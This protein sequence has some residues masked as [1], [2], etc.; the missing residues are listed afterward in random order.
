MS[1]PESDSEVVTL[2]D[3][4][5]EKMYEL[6]YNMNTTDN[7]EEKDKDQIPSSSGHT[8]V[9]LKTYSERR[10]HTVAGNTK[11]LDMEAIDN[12]PGIPE[13]KVNAE[14]K[15]WRKAGADLSDY[16]NYGFDE[17]SW[18]AYCKKQSKVRTAN[19]KLCT[20]IMVQKG[21]TRH[22]EKESCSTCHSSG[23]STILATRQSSV[24]ADVIGG[25]PGSSTRV[26]GRQCLSDEGNNT[27]VVTEMSP[28]KNRITSYHLPPPSTINSLFA[29][30]PP[31]SFLYRPGPPPVSLL[32]TFDSGHSKGS[33]DPST[34]LKPCS[35]GVS[36]LI[37]RSM[38][39]SAGVI[40][41]AKAWECYIWQEK[42]DKDRDRSRQ[43]GHDKDSQRGRDRDRKSCSSS[44][45]SGDE[46]MRHRDTMERGHKH[47]S[48]DRFSGE[49]EQEWR[50]RDKREGWQKSSC[51]RSSS[52]RRG[53]GGEDRDS[54]SGHKK[55]KR[56]R[57]DKETNKM[58][59][60]DRE[61]K[62][63]S[64]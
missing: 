11:G 27:Q 36:S 51:S 62:L 22:E 23:S 42:C 56:N 14:E 21:H 58:F 46:R 9:R 5:E 34:S 38:A 13:L 8:P 63:K 44:H 59:S 43:Y 57:K 32:A 10:T 1:S 30:T 17:E 40:D 49:K 16:F 33:D 47:H 12:I 2:E 60:A 29:F 20:K 41:T 54:Q 64:D 48:F 37:P 61:R 7:K 35:L 26:E 28:E 6:I 18:S 39:F 4:D 3:E 19:R 15:P 45:N 53:D 31:P 50:H 55:A 24:T 25:R 52:R